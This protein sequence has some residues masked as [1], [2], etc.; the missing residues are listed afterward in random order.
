MAASAAAGGVVI[1]SLHPRDHPA[2]EAPLLDWPHKDGPRCMDVRGRS[3]L[4][5]TG[6]SE[7]PP[8]NLL[9]GV[10]SLRPGVYL[11]M[12]LNKR[13]MSQTTAL[14]KWP[15]GWGPGL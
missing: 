10:G 4:W 3:T 7:A 8:S 14:G 1:W 9:P 2:W 11:L 13:V 5:A 12:E 6:A 15:G